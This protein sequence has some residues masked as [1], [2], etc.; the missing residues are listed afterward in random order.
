MDQTQLLRHARQAPH[1]WATP[2]AASSLS[3]TGTTLLLTFTNSFDFKKREGPRVGVGLRKRGRACLPSSR[4]WAQIPVQQ[5]QE[6]KGRKE[7][8]ELDYPYLLQT[9]LVFHLPLYRLLFALTLSQVQENCLAL[10]PEVCVL[11]IKILHLNF[12]LEKVS[13]DVNETFQHVKFTSQ[14]VNTE[15]R[16]RSMGSNSV[17]ISFS[18]P[19]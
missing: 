3:N 5:K 18:F 7:G 6:K 8:R 19:L 10:F 11:T 16:D 4:P 17:L 9:T 12:V 2:S 15:R 1:H 14:S 13:F